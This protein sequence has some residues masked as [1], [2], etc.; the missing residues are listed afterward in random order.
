[1]GGY[2]YQLSKCGSAAPTWRGNIWISHDPLITFMELRGLEPDTTYTVQAPRGC[3][4]AI[5]SSLHPVA[6][7]N[8]GS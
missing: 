1:M 4:T 7:N 5:P 8:E 2:F 3:S 6:T